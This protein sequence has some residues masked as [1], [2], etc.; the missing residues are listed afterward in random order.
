MTPWILLYRVTNDSLLSAL[1]GQLSPRLIL[2]YAPRP[3]DLSQS[4]FYFWALG[5]LFPH[6]VFG[7]VAVIYSRFSDTLARS[8]HSNRK[9]PFQLGYRS[10]V[11]PSTV[12]LF[13]YILSELEGI[14]NS[15]SLRIVPRQLIR[16]P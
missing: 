2:Q 5:F 3:R 1:V 8:H 9:S 7:L 4:C 14:E 15:K 6:L 13:M 11:V 12:F 16:S 10:F